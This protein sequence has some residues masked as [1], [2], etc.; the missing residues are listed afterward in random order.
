MHARHGGW[1]RT[2]L[3]SILL[4]C[5]L[6]G[7][8]ASESTPQAPRSA[9]LTMANR[10]IVQFRAA[11]LGVSPDERA[12]RARLRIQE[13][14]DEGGALKLAVQ[15]LAPGAL[16]QID[17]KAIFMVTAAD[18][19]QLRGE[20]AS[21]AARRAVQVLDKVIAENREGRDLHAMLRAGA[22]A[23]GASLCFATL[24]W[25]L[26]RLRR[27]VSSRLVS[28]LQTQSQRLP[29]THALR[30]LHNGFAWSLPRLLGLV[31]LA[32]AAL[33]LYEWLSLVLA[34]F[35]FTRAWG[36]KLNTTLVDALL[37]LLAGIADTL[38]SLVFAVLIFM[39]ARL[40]AQAVAAL[41]TR[42]ERGEIQLTWLD[43]E[44]A[45]PTRRILSVAIW[46]FALAMA[47]PYLPGA[48]TDAFKGVSVLV[49][50]M[51][52][53]GASS[54]VGQG[55]SGLILTYARV[56]RPGEYVRIGDHEGTVM[57]L[58][59]FTTRIRTGL[60]EELTLPNSLILGSVSKNYSRTV[61][62]PG[63]VLDTVV[64]IGYDT[65]WRQVEAMLVEAALRTP[66][67]IAQP[68][69]RVFQTALSDF[70]P[71]YRLV[72]QALPSEPRPRAEV[73]S[74]LH[75]HIQ[76]VFN[77]QGVQIMSPHYL[78]DPAEPKLAPRKP[79]PAP[80]AR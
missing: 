56:F 5:T 60:G 19:D 24:L 31:Y 57:E 64:T 25:L 63:F 33:I 50:L 44:L 77:E 14:I 20:S 70:Y 2:L 28:R 39:L 16:V 41:F 10:E 17:N 9:S 42:V 45:P 49:G 27:A 79:D 46:L 47:Y 75:A 72:C 55:A 22:I 52:S 43:A 69:P 35:P 23:L 51:L 68:Q 3:A 1:W 76:D 73:L 71:E 4:A 62:A 26:A 38:P 48:H 11:L 7:A 54:L 80:P 61:A 36:E 67:V 78:G 53:I 59:I 18:A 34:R 15:D 58:G 40:A 37:R 13:L 6:H 74:A 29:P 12:H 65:P 32:L 21:E 8:H 66:G 30:A